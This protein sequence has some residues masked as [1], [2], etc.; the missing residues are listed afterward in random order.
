MKCPF[1]QKRFGT[2]KKNSKF[3]GNVDYGKTEGEDPQNIAKN[4]LVIMAAGLKPWQ[5]PIGYF[6][7]NKTTSA[8]Q[9]ELIL[10]A[11]KLLLTKQK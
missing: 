9:S 11:I 10:E 3:V 1:D 2:E 5:I 7:T 6:L 4:V 8:V